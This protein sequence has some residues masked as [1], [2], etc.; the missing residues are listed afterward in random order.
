MP[1]AL[2]AA[3]ADADVKTGSTENIKSRKMTWL[4]GTLVLFVSWC[5]PGRLFIPLV[6]FVVQFAPCPP[7]ASLDSILPRRGGAQAWVNRLAPADATDVA[8]IRNVHEL[9][10]GN[11]LVFVA[12][13]NIIATF[14]QI[15]AISKNGCICINSRLRPL[16]AGKQ[17]ALPTAQPAV[18]SAHSLPVWGLLT[19]NG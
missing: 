19:Q 11:H 12:T 16:L 18:R 15:F 1:A 3:L 5:F 7:T 2:P 9:H 10:N 4:P 17:L 8:L 14:V 13:A 6:Q